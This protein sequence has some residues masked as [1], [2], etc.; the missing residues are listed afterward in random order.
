MTMFK[1]KKPVKPP[2]EPGPSRLRLP[3]EVGMRSFSGI[4]ELM[5]D[6]KEK[7]GCLI[8]LPWTT[9]KPSQRFIL[10]VQWD[11]GSTQP[12]WSLYEENEVEQRIVWS[13]PWNP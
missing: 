13:Q 11:K 12:L 5:A 1:P 6:A 9:S 2:E 8:E 10:T 7:T 3:T 4:K